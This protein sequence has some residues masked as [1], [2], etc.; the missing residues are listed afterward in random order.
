MDRRKQI[1]KQIASKQKQKESAPNTSSATRPGLD[2]FAEQKPE[3]T[4]FHKVLLQLVI[5]GCLFFA[6]GIVYDG[7]HRNLDSVQAVVDQ[8]FEEHFQF[9]AVSSYFESVFGSPLALLPDQRMQEGSDDVVNYALPASG[10]IKESFSKDR[11]GILLE[12]GLGEDV[13]AVKGGHVIELYE[14]E[15]AS[16]QVVEL[17]HQDG[18][19]SVYGMLDD[20]N[21]RPYDILSKGAV[22][23]SVVEADEEQA[24]MFYFGLKQDGDYIDPSTVINF[25]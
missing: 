12:T 7:N 9:A 11:K 3:S 13:K 4:R 24:G 10:T 5:A 17:Q 2:K 20:V 19:V 25:D 8:A 23:G 14:G 1:E 18:T 22:I 16:G 6:I 21:V 15:D